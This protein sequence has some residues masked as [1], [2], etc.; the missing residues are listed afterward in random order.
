MAKH[1]AMFLADPLDVDVS[2]NGWAPCL[3]LRGTG[4]EV[5]E[6][7]MHLG[8]VAEADERPAARRQLGA[9]LEAIGAAYRL[10][11]EHSDVA[12]AGTAP[13]DVVVELGQLRPNSPAIGPDDEEL[14]AWVD[15][16]STGGVI[17]RGPDD[18]ED[19]DEDAAVRSTETTA[20]SW[21]ES[22]D[23]ERAGYYQ[24]H[25]MTEAEYRAAWGDR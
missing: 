5:P 8:N 15:A 23:V 21:A 4:D 24:A 6:L 9:L 20:L 3:R 19:D 2:W 12:P 17:I 11:D 13:D 22:M 7:T 14:A 18:D 1:R 10:M 16:A 25:P